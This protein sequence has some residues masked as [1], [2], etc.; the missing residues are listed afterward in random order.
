MLTWFHRNGAALAAVIFWMFVIGY[1]SLKSPQTPYINAKDSSYNSI[2]TKRSA[3]QPVSFDAQQPS[4]CYA[5]QRHEEASNGN[6]LWMKPGE[7]ALVIVTLLLFGATAGLVWVAHWTAERQ[8]RAYLRV[9]PKGMDSMTTQHVLGHVIFENAGNISAT[10]VWWIIKGP[11][12]GNG[13]WQPTALTNEDCTRGPT[14]ISVKGEF[15][16]G[17]AA[18]LPERP[19]KNEYWFIWGRAHYLDG[20]NKRRFINFC[21]S[22]P[23]ARIVMDKEPFG[24]IGYSIRAKYARQH[25][26]G[27]E[28]D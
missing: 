28:A 14:V 6:I 3:N 7:L 22:Y 25:D 27:N 20:F 18:I 8:L 16:R 2:E 24:T 5:A 23:A 11:T 19:E 13:G 4:C 12:K 21:H 10:D 26:Y 1:G 9:I 15:R 17:T